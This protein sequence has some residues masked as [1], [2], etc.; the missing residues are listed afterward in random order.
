MGD[1]KRILGAPY[2]LAW[3]P[4]GA[5]R[6]LPLAPPLLFINYNTL[7]VDELHRQQLLHKALH[8]ILP[9]VLGNV[10]F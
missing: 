5:P 7:L 3:A 2:F 9:E 10:L 8:H 4:G 6:P 1:S